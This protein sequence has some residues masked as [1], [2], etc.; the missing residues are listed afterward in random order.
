MQLT[1]I[2]FTTN[3]KLTARQNAAGRQPLINRPTPAAISFTKSAVSRRLLKDQTWHLSS[4]AVGSSFFLTCIWID[5]DPDAMHSRT[6][7]NL[8]SMSTHPIAGR[9]WRQKPPVSTAV[10]PAIIPVGERVNSTA[11][12]CSCKASMDWIQQQF[13]YGNA[14]ESDNPAQG[15]S[16]LSISKT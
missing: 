10:L 13:R 3:R 11:H 15:F 6:V 5:L 12:T 1:L 4:S 8:S 9:T 2:K 14:P 16:D 7:T